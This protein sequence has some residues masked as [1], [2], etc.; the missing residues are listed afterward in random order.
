MVILI[1]IPVCGKD[2]VPV[3]ECFTVKHKM[4]PGQAACHY[5]FIVFRSGCQHPDDSGPESDEEI[6][7]SADRQGR[8]RTCS[9]DRSGQFHLCK[10]LVHKGFLPRSSR[11]PKDDVFS[12]RKKVHQ[13][14]AVLLS[15]DEM[16]SG[17]VFVI[18]ERAVH[19]G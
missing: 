19:R 10:H 5:L 8:E 6:V 2:D 3:G 9:K 11:F 1:Q 13:D 14:A 12:V 17:D 7:R 18:L 16:L 15:P 4:R